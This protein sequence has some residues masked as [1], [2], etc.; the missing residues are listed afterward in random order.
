LR[1]G[2]DGDAQVLVDARQPEMANDDAALTQRGGEVA[3]V[4][5]RMTD[6]D[7]VGG[8]RENLE[9]ER[10]QRQTQRLATAYHRM[11]RRFEMSFV[12]QSGDGAGDCQAVKGI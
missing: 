8:R 5:P 6:E 12:G 1:I 9:S 3:G 10:P 11:P 4:T 7:E 2:A